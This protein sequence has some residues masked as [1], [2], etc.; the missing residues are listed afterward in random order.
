[1]SSLHAQSGDRRRWLF[2]AAVAVFL[3]GGA[4]GAL[5]WKCC[6]ATTVKQ[7][8][9]PAPRTVRPAA[10]IVREFKDVR[11]PGFGNS[12]S[13]EEF[14]RQIT[15]AFEKQNQLALELLESHP[16][17]RNLPHLLFTRWSNLVNG[18]QR[19]D[20]V[21]EETNAVL[22]KPATRNVIAV[23]KRSRAQAAIRSPSIDDAR[24]EEWMESAVAAEP[25]DADISGHV[26]ELFA[27]LRTADPKRQR[28]LSTRAAALYGTKAQGGPSRLQGLPKVLE[29]LGTP[30]DL[31]FD[32]AL[33]GGR[34]RAE[35]GRPVLVHMWSAGRWDLKP[36]ERDPDVDDLARA[37]PALKSAGVRVVAVDGLGRTGGR[38]DPVALARERGVAWPYAVE[39]VRSN[40]DDFAP[41]GYS[42]FLWVDAQ[43]RASAWCRSL[44]PLLGC[45]GIVG[46]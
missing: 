20:P 43:G 40:V 46:R 17:D 30:L 41:G 15:A 33:G 34:W 29:K 7:D 38:A 31:E 27:E 5:A 26:L 37:L 28:A 3:V 1:M 2:A 11:T 32:D 6:A 45:A 35:P 24:A 8:P 19:Y 4:T 42:S 39:T 22:S 13:E 16:R 36:G 23:A 44:G 12:L 18:M 14:D 25:A 21:V 10:E 9:A